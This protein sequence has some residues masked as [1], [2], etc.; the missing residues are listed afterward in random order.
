MAAAEANRLGHHY[1]GTEHLL[2]GLVAQRQGIAA[3][4][5]R[6]RDVGDLAELRQMIIR[7]LNEGG[8]HLRPPI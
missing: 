6:R 4:E 1:L 2:L 3:D 7:V 5:L 8:P